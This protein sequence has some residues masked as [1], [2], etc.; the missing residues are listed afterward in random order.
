MLLNEIFEVM[1]EKDDFDSIGGFIVNELGRMPN[2]G[3]EVMV[4]GLTLR[5]LSVT[6][7]RI[8]R[9]RVTKVGTPV[10]RGSS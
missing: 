6:G 4:N 10:E 2:V 8:K 9:V 1:I 3:D 5:V 7:R